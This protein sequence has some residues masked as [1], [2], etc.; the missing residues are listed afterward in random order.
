MRF[1]ILNEEDKHSI[2]EL[3]NKVFEKSAV[4]IDL[5]SNNY[6]FVGIKDNEL[7]A[8][9]MLTYIIDPIKNLKKMHIDYF[10]VNENYRGKGIGRMLFDEIEKL[11]IS[12]GI[13]VL[14]LTSNPRRESARRLYI[15]KGM[16]LLD[17]NVFIK[18]IRQ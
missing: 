10:C 13:D 12:E 3:I 6:K 7:L 18:N 2:L 11:A 14:E 1:G 15:D 4:D 17:T 16:I 9:S 5:A 8:V